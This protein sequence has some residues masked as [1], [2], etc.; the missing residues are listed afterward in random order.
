[1]SAGVVIIIMILMLSLLSSSVGA[2]MYL[3]YIPIPS[4]LTTNTTTTT[5]TTAAAAA[6][7]ST[8]PPA[9]TTPA[10]TVVTGGGSTSTSS[11]SGGTVSS[12]GTS[13]D[14]VNCVGKWERTTTCNATAC[15]TSGFFVDTYKVTTPAANGGAACPTKDGGRRPSAAKCNAPAC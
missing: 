15:G 14:P 13:I 4:F 12:T 10:A 11:G 7:D 1:M 5:T 9:D 2:G 6:T 8:P 3:K